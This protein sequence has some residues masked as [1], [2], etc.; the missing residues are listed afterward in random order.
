MGSAQSAHR[1]VAGG[2]HIT[3]AIHLRGADRAAAHSTR[4]PCYALQAV[5]LFSAQLVG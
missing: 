3:V 4:L 5:L 2:S 1:A